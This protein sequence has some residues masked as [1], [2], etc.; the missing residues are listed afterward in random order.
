MSMQTI[1]GFVIDPIFN[2]TLIKDLNDEIDSGLGYLNDNLINY[3][4][5]R[6]RFND[7]RDSRLNILGSPLLTQLQII[8][9]KTKLNDI[10]IIENITDEQLIS[11]F[12]IIEL[13]ELSNNSTH[14]AIESHL[15][16]ETEYNTIYVPDSFQWSAGITD[17]NINLNG[18]NTALTIRNSFSFNID[19]G[20]DNIIQF[21]LWLS[22]T[23]F[24]IEYPLS[25]ITKIIPPCPP[26]YFLDVSLFTDSLSTLITSSTFSFGVLHPDIHQTDHTGLLSYRTKFVITSN[27][28][29]LI[30]FG[31]LYQGH[32][33]TSLEIRKAIRE[34]LLRL[35]IAH[36][37]KWK[38]V[39]PDLFVIAEFYFV[40]IWDN[41]INRLERELYP[42]IL[43]CNADTLQSVKLAFPDTDTTW[44]D[45]QTEI[46]MNSKLEI[47]TLSLPDVLND[48]NYISLKIIHPTYQNHSSDSNT[49]KFMETHT[50]DFGR[51][52]AK[53]MSI[54]AGESYITDEFVYNTF[55]DRTYLSFVVSGVEYHILRKED[56]PELTP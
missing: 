33:P 19:L 7:N 22:S 47:F 41:V 43:L 5:I 30:P 52:F 28:I 26:E 21:K 35:G 53:A 46:V 13:I 12:N 32:P 25:T 3:F 20:D 42:S 54:L 50:Q 44:I 24:E 51:R 18:T 38:S 14:I 4:S 31:I 6:S 16:D 15:T 9:D 1:Y 8:F 27:N 48:P 55:H 34:Y 11:L 49:F 39:F 2:N 23:K 36:E 17:I 37:D 29:R 10:S 45:T 40:P 56:Y